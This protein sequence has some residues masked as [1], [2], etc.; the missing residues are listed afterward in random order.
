MTPTTGTL[1]FFCGKPASGKSTLTTKLSMLPNTVALHGDQWLDELYP[2]GMDSP[3]QYV[4]CAERLQQALGA[5]VVRLLSM[6]TSVVLDF[7]AN[8]K[9]TRQWMK[10]LY[11]TAKASHAL[12]YLKTK[13]KTRHERLASRLNGENPHRKSLSMIQAFETPSPEEGFNLITLD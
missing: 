1:Y 5:H 10:E 3:S 7:P 4:E 12:Y 13:E 11:A 8:T 9:A 2:E 6:G